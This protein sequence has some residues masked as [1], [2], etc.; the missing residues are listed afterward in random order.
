MSFP[1]I[2]I[3]IFP[4]PPSFHVERGQLRVMYTELENIGA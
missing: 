1:V 4:G 2:E 3:Y